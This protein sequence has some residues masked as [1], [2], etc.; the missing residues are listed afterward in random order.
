VR[1]SKLQ[2]QPRPTCREAALR[3]QLQASYH[4]Q[5][6]LVQQHQLL[7]AER[8]DLYWELMQAVVTDPMTSLPNHQAVI[9]RLDEVVIHCQRTQRSCAVLFL[10]LDHFK[11]VNDAWGHRAGDALLREVA[12]QLRMAVRPHDVVGRYGGEEFLILLTDVDLPGASQM[13]EYLRSV[14]GS[15]SCSW[16]SDARASAVPICTTAS[17]G[18]AISPLHGVSGEALLEAA[19]CAMYQAKATG[20]NR[21]ALADIEMRF[22]QPLH[23]SQESMVVQALTAAAWAHD[24]GTQAHAQRLVQLAETLA[25]KLQLPEAEI[26]LVGLAALL[27]DIGKIGIAEAIL[28][29]PGPL[30]QEE[31]SIIQRHPEIGRQ[32]LEHIG[33]VFG[34]VADIVA[35]HHE[36]WDGGGYPYGLAK[37]AIPLSARILCVVDSYDAMTSPRPYRREPLT[38]EKARAQL[39]RGAASDYDPRVVEM[40]LGVLDEQEKKLRPLEEAKAAE[41][42]EESPPSIGAITENV[43]QHAAAM[44]QQLEKWQQQQATLS[45][46]IEVLQQKQHYL[47]WRIQE[48]GRQ[49]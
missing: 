1:S 27:H 24:R 43:Q 48:R 26:E 45:Q 14:V 39:Q 21:V 25:R 34:R 28:H 41:P 44:R 38:S 18:V 16:Q 6:V 3:E 20:R 42:R 33:G 4:E 47:A 15:L 22:P 32:L 8:D 2:K 37:E 5:D 17:I 29:K 49:R 40:F 13:A 31:R 23:Q 35:A 9:N 11:Y 30:T 10:D 19:D 7:L 36:H 12:Q 46:R